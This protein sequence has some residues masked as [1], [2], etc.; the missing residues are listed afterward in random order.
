[1]KKTTCSLSA[2]N[3]VASLLPVG[4]LRTETTVAS[5]SVATSVVVI[6]LPTSELR[7]AVE[8][9]ESDAMRAKKPLKTE[10]SPPLTREPFSKMWSPTRSI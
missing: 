6:F 9:V 4:V 7:S 3:A 2:V 8:S 5:V 10:T 1:M